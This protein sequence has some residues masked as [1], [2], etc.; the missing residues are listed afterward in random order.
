M[1]GRV[2]KVHGKLSTP[3]ASSMD[4]RSQAWRGGGR[5]GVAAGR[6]GEPIH[7]GVYGEAAISE[8]ASSL[9]TDRAGTLFQLPQRGGAAASAEQADMT[10]TLFHL[11][12]RMPLRGGAM[13][14]GRKHIRCMAR[15]REH[16][17]QE[18]SQAET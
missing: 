1:A 16:T 8:A 9:Q 15:R 14:G 5:G 6:G 18:Q 4:S 3:A 7:L 11:P 12:L 17:I 10:D 13:G 2:K